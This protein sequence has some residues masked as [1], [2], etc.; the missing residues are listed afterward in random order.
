MANVYRTGEVSEEDRT[1]LAGA[2]A[3][4]TD[5]TQAQAKTRVDT[6]VTEAQDARQEAE[7]AIAAAKAEAEQAAE[8]AKEEDKKEG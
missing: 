2:V 1:Y 8:E 7:E 3:A 5:L 6:V 4:R